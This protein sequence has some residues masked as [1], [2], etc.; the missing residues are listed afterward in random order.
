MTNLTF[1][2]LL[3]IFG[4]SLKYILSYKQKIK[5]ENQKIV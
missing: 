4:L 5:T 1:I 2:S 3:Y